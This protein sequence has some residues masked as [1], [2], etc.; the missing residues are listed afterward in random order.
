MWDR[1]IE[2]IGGSGILTQADENVMAMYAEAYS[3]WRQ[4]KEM[5]AET[6]AVLIDDDTGR[7][8]KSPYRVILNE[9]IA[10]MQSLGAE[11]GLSPVARTR[12]KITMQKPPVSGV[13]CRDRSQGPPP[14]SFE[15]QA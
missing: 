5:I 9:A 1:L 15:V 14:P 7:A 3:D 12:L 2:V 11:I 4:A 6:G 13:S 8:Y 10:Q